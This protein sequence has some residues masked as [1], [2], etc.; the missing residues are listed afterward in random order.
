[1]EVESIQGM[2]VDH[3]HV[4]CVIKYYMTLAMEQCFE[5]HKCLK[6]MLDV[7]VRSNN[8]ERMD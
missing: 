4:K 6:G 7:S 8:S 2:A 3:F 1:M 5:Y